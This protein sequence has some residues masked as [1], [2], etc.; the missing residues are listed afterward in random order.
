MGILIIL[1]FLIRC[2]RFLDEPSLG[3]HRLPKCF[4]KFL[5]FVRPDKSKITFYLVPITI[6]YPSV[7]LF[8]FL[9]LFRNA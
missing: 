2:E 1:K 7:F 9:Y 5:Y 3:N 6:G 4:C 8:L